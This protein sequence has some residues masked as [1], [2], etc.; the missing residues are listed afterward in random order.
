MPTSTPPGQGGRRPPQILKGGAPADE[1]GRSGDPGT[2]RPAGG[3]GQIGECLGRSRG[4][5]TTKIHVAADGRCRPL[6]LLLTPG[7]YGDGP[8]LQPVL[9]QVSVPRAGVGRP[10]TRP[11]HV[12]ADK[13]YTSRRNRRYLRR[14][15]ISHTIPERLDQRRHRQNRGSR[16]GRPTGFDRERYK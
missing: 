13:A 9:E 12:L 1:P 10:R 11:D 3:G 6:A 8:Q 2:D 15:G 14:R 7:H 4:G 16:G 5:F